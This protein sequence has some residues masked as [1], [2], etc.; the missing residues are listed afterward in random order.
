MANDYFDGLTVFYDR[1]TAPIRDISGFVFHEGE[2]ITDGE[3]AYMFLATINGMAKQM[4]KEGRR[5][6]HVACE[7]GYKD[8]YLGN[9][10][11][12][13]GSERFPGKE[14]VADAIVAYAQ[15]NGNPPLP[16]KYLD[17]FASLKKAENS[18]FKEADIGDVAL[19]LNDGKPFVY[20][21]ME[22]RMMDFMYESFRSEAGQK[23]ILEAWN[24]LHP[25]PDDEFIAATPYERKQLFYD[26]PNLHEI[27]I[28]AAP[29]AWMDDDGIAHT[30]EI[31]K[32]MEHPKMTEISNALLT[33]KLPENSSL[34]MQF[35]EKYSDESIV[36][37]C[38]MD[39][40]QKCLNSHGKGYLRAC[41]ETLRWNS[42]DDLTER[43]LLY[44]ST[45]EEFD[46][47]KPIVEKLVTRQPIAASPE[48][49]R[50]DRELAPYHD[51]TPWG[52]VVQKYWERHPKEV[53]KT[54]HDL[55]SSNAAL[56]KNVLN[57][58]NHDF[59]KQRTSIQRRF[60]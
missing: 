23:A 51:C 46:N 36:R 27:Q 11:L 50:K 17:D 53:R 43:V 3:Y 2:E 47:M 19:A 45:P 30:G 39:T 40:V 25:L 38:A 54:V 5:D 1:S 29:Y 35:K 28:D 41:A 10:Q 56:R 49:H 4:A 34:S 21:Y 55:L 7:I 42:I 26:F 52:E 13:L 16:Q 33:G 24:T 57:C 9:M 60:S 31:D 48:I 32:A 20:P 14:T 6:F 59:E 44:V 58:M 8:S 18:C 22:N 12:D 15:S 37:Q